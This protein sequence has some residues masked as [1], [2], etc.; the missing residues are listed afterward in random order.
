MRSVVWLVLVPLAAAATAFVCQLPAGGS[1]PALVA[2]NVLICS[3]FALV[4]AMIARDPRMF[5][6]GA[7]LVLSGLLWASRWLYTWDGGV[8]AYLGFEGWVL[9]WVPTVVAVLTYPTGR[10]DGRVERA[11]L[12]VTVVGLPVTW[13]AAALFTTAEWVEYPAGAWWPTLVTSFPLSQATQTGAVLFTTALAVTLLVLLVRRVRRASRLDR[14]LL[15]PIFATFVVAGL[16]A[17]QATWYLAD[18][19]RSRISLGQLPSMLSVLAVPVAFGVLHLRRQ[20]AHAEVGQSLAELL[21]ASTPD[22]AT[23]RTGQSRSSAG[24]DGDAVD[25]AM[26]RDLVRRTL[27]APSTD[28][29]V[30][31]GAGGYWDVDGNPCRPPLDDERL[32]I[33]IRSAD[34]VLVGLLVARPDLDRHLDVVEATVAAISLLLENA[35]LE[36]MMRERAELAETALDRLVRDGVAQHQNLR[37]Q[38]RATTGRRLLAVAAQLG[39]VRR[40]TDDPR[41]TEAVET[42][43]RE[44]RAAFRDIRALAAGTGPTVL[45]ESGLRAAIDL[46]AGTLPI[47]VETDVVDGRFAPEIELAVYYTVSEALTNVYRH[48]AARRTRVSVSVCGRDLVVRVVDDGRGGADIRSGRGLTGLADRVRAVGGQFAVESP[49]GGPTAVTATVPAAVA[50]R[51]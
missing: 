17:S 18:F 14:H 44:L 36:M 43:H 6:L 5:G 38:L 1:D 2:L 39:E 8:W 23:G 31:D 49:P 47:A 15:I 21:V 27:D 33:P 26:V 19:T 16:A 3:V 40:Q 32:L 30:A 34:D 51:T 12:L 9:F 28:L 48:A 10:T 4:G 13:N 35:R 20:I 45:R 24:L 46:A 41:V 11:F 37:D 42:A 50:T 29:L 25:P 22:R 7:C